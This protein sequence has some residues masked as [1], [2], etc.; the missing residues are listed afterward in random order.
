[1][2]RALQPGPFGPFQVLA[3]LAQAGLYRAVHLPSGAPCALKVLRAFDPEERTR[4][5][6]EGELLA[7]F[8]TPGLIRY[9]ASGE[10]GG[11]HYLATAWL[12]GPTLAER[13]HERGPLEARAALA[14][15]RR[16]AETLAPLHRGGV[17]HRDL[18]PANVILAGEGPVL[19]D[20]GLAKAQ[21][22]PV[23]H[24][25]ALLG[26]HGYAAPEQLFGG[27]RVDHRADLYGIGALLYFALVGAA[28]LAGLPLEEVVLRARESPVLLPARLAAGPLGSELNEVLARTL[29]PEPAQRFAN[30]S[31]LAAAL[32]AAAE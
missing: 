13:V 2:A 29:T 20:L 3:P 12:E 25:G 31:A 4:F 32:A 10:Q 24:S 30:A 21:D 16:L 26:T 9:V 7:R 28:P 1:M 17:V 5:V 6:R 14:V 15:A 27:S 22:D 19:L 8:A 23:T 11:L 18:R